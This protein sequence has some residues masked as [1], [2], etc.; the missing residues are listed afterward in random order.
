MGSEIPVDEAGEYNDIFYELDA[1]RVKNSIFALAYFSPPIITCAFELLPIIIRILK[2]VVSDDRANVQLIQL[3]SEVHEPL[4]KDADND[5]H[6]DLPS[7]LERIHK[8]VKDGEAKYE[9]IEKELALIK[10]NKTK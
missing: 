5:S 7:E 9:I 3:I 1:E 2:N 10:K 4:A 8:I 6:F